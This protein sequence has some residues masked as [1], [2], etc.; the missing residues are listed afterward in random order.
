MSRRLSGVQIGSSKSSRVIGVGA[1]IVGPN[2]LQSG[3]MARQP[4]LLQF[5]VVLLIQ[6][7]SREGGRRPLLDRGRHRSGPR[8]SI[9][10][11]E[12][13][14]FSLRADGMDDGT[15]LCFRML[16]GATDAPETHQLQP[17]KYLSRQRW[18]MPQNAL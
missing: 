7:V 6:A 12:N 9:L 16:F 10:G 3:I 5:F 13:S 8:V 11:Y 18:C 1:F 14:K 15:E 17:W 4:L 2:L